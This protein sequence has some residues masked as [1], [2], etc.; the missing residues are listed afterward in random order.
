M[1]KKTTTPEMGQYVEKDNYRIE[2][3]YSQDAIDK[4]LIKI[5][6]KDDKEMVFTS[7]ELLEMITKNL[8]NKELALAL[9]EYEVGMKVLSTIQVMRTIHFKSDKDYKAGD[10]IHFSYVQPYPYF[11]ALLEEGYGIAKTK[12]DIETIP[13]AV[14]AEAKESMMAKNK[15]LAEL[16]NKTTLDEAA[17]QKVETKNE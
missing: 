3:N 10:E 1:K 7:G 5:I 14:M 6:P 15:Q 4:E 9:S 2:I 12:G 11:L 17:T 8:K 16:I 13:L